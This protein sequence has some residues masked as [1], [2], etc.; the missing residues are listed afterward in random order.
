MKNLFYLLLCIG[1]VLFT[2]CSPTSVSTFAQEVFGISESFSLFCY[3]SLW[4]WIIF[5]AIPWIIGMVLC[6]GG[7]ITTSQKHYDKSGRY[8]GETQTGTGQFY[9]DDVE[10]MYV[11]ANVC[12]I[13]FPLF[14]F[15]LV[16]NCGN[17]DL[18]SHAVEFSSHSNLNVF[19]HII[20]IPIPFVIGWG[21]HKLLGEL[22]SLIR[23]WT[24]IVASI[25][26]GVC[27]LVRFAMFLFN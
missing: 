12:F 19:L 2:S 27:L 22:L 6:S 3:H 24:S 10:G 16:Y 21:V 23:Y 15:W 20:A 18:Y 8:I 17:G 1:C 13:A 25:F 9:N 11:V 5:I 7:E 14:Y 26:V 4:W